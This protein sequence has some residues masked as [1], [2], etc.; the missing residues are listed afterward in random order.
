MDLIGLTG[1]IGSGKSTVSG[2][3]R[4]LGATVV[5]ADEAARAVEA[6]GEP[7]FEEI[8][9]EFGPGVAREGGLD[10]AA[11]AAVVFH[12]PEKL[13]RLNAI[14]HPRAREWMAAR[15]AEAA[16]RGE[17]RV[18]LE[19]PLLY[20]T[21]GD[22]QFQSVILV[23]ADPEL[24]VR[25]LVEQRGFDEADARARLA[26]QMPIEEKRARATYVI[27]NSNGR[28]ATREQTRRVWAEITGGA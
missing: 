27:D 14:V 25:R 6:P 5:D 22:A 20:E 15:T 2:Y 7:A 12:D 19:I 13:Q 26:S 11:L 18:V 1:G 23:Y 24:A 4:E 3:L 9:R 8:A 17:P 28:E 21:R 10:R 16:Q